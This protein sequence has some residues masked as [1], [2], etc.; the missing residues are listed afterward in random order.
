MEKTKKTKR[1]SRNIRIR[2]NP[3]DGDKYVKV[4]LD[5]SFDFLEILSLR[6][7]QAD[8]YRK[9]AAD[10]GV[11]VG[12][13]VANGGFGVPNAKVSVFIPLDS[14]ETNPLIR[15]LYPYQTTKDINNEGVRYN[16]LEEP[17]PSQAPTNITLP[18]FGNSITLPQK[19][20]DNAVGTFPSKRKVLDN[21][22][23]LEI[24]DKYYKF[25]TSTNFAGDFMIFGVPTGNQNLHMDVNLGDMDFVSL[26]PYDLIEQGYTETLFES[27]TTFKKGTDLDSLVQVQSKDFAVNVLPFWGDLEENEVGIN[28]V[29]FTLNT[30]IIPNA[31]FFGSIFTDSKKSS[32]RKKCQPRKTLGKNCD[33]STGVGSIE[34]I[35]R[36]SD[37]SNE[38]EFM[39]IE[40]KQIDENGNWAFTVP[41]NLNRVITDELGNLVPSDDPNVGIATTANVRF[42]IA[43]NEHLDAI[44]FRNAHYLVPNMYNNYQFGNDTEDFDFFEMRWKKVYTVTNYIPRYQKA[45]NSQSLLHT[46]IKDIG[47]CENTQSFPFNRLKVDLSFLYT[48]LCIF[49]TLFAV[50]IDLLN[51]LIG[52]ILYQVIFRFVCLL[53][54]PLSLKKF[55][56][57]MCNSC[58][59]LTSSLASPPTPTIPFYWE[60]PI[61]ILSLITQTPCPDCIKCAACYNPADDDNSSSTTFAFK[62]VTPFSTP[63]II[64]L[65]TVNVLIDGTYTVTSTNFSS[66]SPSAIGTYAFELQVVGGT[67]TKVLLINQSGLGT[68]PATYTTFYTLVL[69]SGSFPSMISS[70]TV[71]FTLQPNEIIILNDINDSLA[72]TYPIDETQYTYNDNGQGAV[73]QAIIN[74]DGQLGSISILS[75][76][77]GAGYA[78]YNSSTPLTEVFVLP[79]SVIGGSNKTIAFSI[80]AFQTSQTIG[81][82]PI[83]VDCDNFD[84][85]DCKDRCITCPISVI[86]LECNDAPFTDAFEWASCVKEN[87]AENLGVVRY[88]FYNDWVIGSL[89]SVLFDYKSKFKKKGKSLERYCDYN[90]RA[91]NVDVPTFCPTTPPEKDPNFKRRRNRC[92]DSY[93]AENFIFNDLNGSCSATSKW[94]MVD[95]NSPLTLPQGRGLIVEYDGFFYYMARHDIEI[96]FVT[97]SNLAA[98][99]L[100]VSEKYNL[101]FATNL[102]ELGS[103]V[104]CDKDGEPFIINNVEST[105]YQKDDGVGVLFNLSDCFNACPV[106]RTGTQLMSQAGIE[107]AFAQIAD[108]PPI[109]TGDDGTDYE[110]IGV[111]T[112]IPDY[113][114]NSGIIIFDRTDIVL[115]RLLCENFNYYNV[116]GTHASAEVPTDSPLT[117]PL[118]PPPTYPFETNPAYLEEIPTDTPPVNDILEF[119]IDSCTGFDDF[120]LPSKRMP[121]YYMYFGIRQGQSSL[122][123][124]RKNY[125]DRCID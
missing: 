56:A 9:F 67:L 116:L 13:V 113:D 125:F 88:F 58:Y 114:G 83:S 111:D 71:E 57:C 65:P 21:D 72:G 1:M 85:S 80:D 59:R 4:K 36:V 41:M 33:L 50:V 91:P 18:F 49:I 48:I 107:I 87:L 86:Q 123:K 63:D 74:A 76:D 35:R 101:L 98:N 7:T 38:V 22:I 28:R 8:V 100:T 94:K 6:L 53:K 119:T 109:Y 2:T 106:N 23:W 10:Y 24:Y 37:T 51:R 44:K 61:P 25:T 124:L 12:R 79:S 27:K 99:N 121:P 95:I 14:N 64:I 46:G 96:N 90:C 60:T 31:T 110:L 39:Q 62:E 102:I 92:Y 16:L 66:V 19:N 47:E 73:F 29:D 103:M 68:T 77:G 55:A 30:E 75:G 70:G 108:T 11:I 42:R 3:N 82:P 40:S 120:G 122:E 20:C 93:I 78:S 5:H 26:K 104:S 15:Q 97:N 117:A 45:Q 17:S 34:M 89:Y 84:I 112:D 115:R 118:A 54:H 69:D 105:T 52:F 43:L 32:V 81:T